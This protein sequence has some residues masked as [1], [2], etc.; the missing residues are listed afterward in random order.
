[1]TRITKTEELPVSVKA[2]KLRQACEIVMTT[3]AFSLPWDELDKDDAI[4]TKVADSLDKADIEVVCEDLFPDIPITSP[5][6]LPGVR[7]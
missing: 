6:Y 4:V 7:L 3:D 5:T 1:M 2:S